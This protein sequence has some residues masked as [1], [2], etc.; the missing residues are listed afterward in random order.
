MLREY[1]RTVRLARAGELTDDDS[2][3]DTDPLSSAALSLLKQFAHFRYAMLANIEPFFG[4][5]CPGILP[6]N[7]CGQAGHGFGKTERRWSNRGEGN[8]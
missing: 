8:G 5:H 4:V 3:T 6:G 7:A 1:K 2:A